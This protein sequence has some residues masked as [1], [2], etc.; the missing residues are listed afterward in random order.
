[1]CG[2]NPEYSPIPAD[3]ASVTAPSVWGPAPMLLNRDELVDA[4]FRE[5]DRAQRMK[6]PLTVILCGIDG[7]DGL[8]S[9]LGGSVLETAEREIVRRIVQHLRCYDSIGRYGDGEFAVILPGCNSFSAVPMA[10]RLGTEVFGPTIPTGSD[11]LTISACTGVAGSGGR[12]PIVVLR[13]AE[14]AL[15]SAREMGPGSVQRCSYDAEPDPATF[16]VSVVGGADSLGASHEV[17]S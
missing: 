6:T 8:R 3:T 9:R 2:P 4:L 16:L 15:K 7:R 17:N 13:N 5:T 10:E 1:M 12:S 11:E 14:Q